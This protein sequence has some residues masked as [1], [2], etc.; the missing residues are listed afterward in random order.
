VW[1]G[2]YQA[3]GWLE[4]S[5]GVWV[6]LDGRLPQHLT[7]FEISPRITVWKC[8]P[9]AIEGHEWQ[10]PV[11]LAPTG[12]GSYRS[13]LDRV[14]G[15]DGWG[16][17]AELEALQRQLLAIAQGVP[18]GVTEEERDAAMT[19]LAVRLLSCGQWVDADLLRAAGWLSERMLVRVICAAYGKDVL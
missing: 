1:G 9:G 18:Q 13:A 3:T 14:L 17:P 2:A 11:L 19:D 7:R 5:R 15:R 6:H 10:V 16:A 12:S 4:H 8:V